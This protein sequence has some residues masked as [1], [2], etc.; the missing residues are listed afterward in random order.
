MGSSAQSYY[1]ELD[2][3]F[4]KEQIRKRKKYIQEHLKN[5]ASINPMSD[6]FEEFEFLM[7]NKD[8]IL[9]NRKL[10]ELLG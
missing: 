6:R 10:I 2:E 7:K 1:D 5:I 9:R 4:E 3:E 8:K